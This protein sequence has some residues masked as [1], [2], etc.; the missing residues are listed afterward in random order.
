[1]ANRKLPGRDAFNEALATVAPKLPTNY[2]AIIRH[3]RPDLDQQKI[4]HVKAG[5]V[6]DW[7]ILEEMQK[8]AK[9]STKA[10]AA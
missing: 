4:Y 7:V 5:K 8:V 2:A 9:E 6:L 1:M 3:R 10:L